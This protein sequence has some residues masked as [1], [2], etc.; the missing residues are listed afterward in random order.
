MDGCAPLNCTHSD[1]SADEATPCLQVTK[2]QAHSRLAHAQHAGVCPQL[3]ADVPVCVFDWSVLAWMF[4]LAVA[5]VF[6]RLG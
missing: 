3:A 5:D 6:G 2:R 4:T 1:A